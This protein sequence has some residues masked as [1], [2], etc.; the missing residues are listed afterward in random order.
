MKRSVNAILAAFVAVSTV[1][2]SASAFAACFRENE[3]ATIRGVATTRAVYLEPGDFAWAPANGFQS[4]T[5]LVTDQPVCV[6]DADGLSSESTRIVQL[7]ATGL[8]EARLAEGLPI[9]VR[10][11]L[12]PGHTAHHFQALVLVANEVS[13]PQ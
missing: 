11:N 7:S 3:V 4:Y 12:F 13:I 1:L 10:G 8:D 6:R 2:A 5:V 9:V